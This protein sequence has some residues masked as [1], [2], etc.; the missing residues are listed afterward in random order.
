VLQRIGNQGLRFQLFPGTWHDAMSSI[1]VEFGTSHSHELR[2]RR[3]SHDRREEAQ[4]VSATTSSISSSSSPFPSIDVPSSSQNK[5]VDQPFQLDLSS[6]KL[7][8]SIPV[9]LLPQI[10][11]GCKNCTTRGSLEVLTGSFDIDLGNAV[12]PGNI[13]QNGT[14]MISMPDGFN[15]HIELGLNVSIDIGFEIPIIDVPIQGF[16]V[17]TLCSMITL[18]NQNRSQR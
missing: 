6:E 4:T 12:T 11:F 16:T 3:H 10:S 18:A 9:P 2:V 8:Q 7:D 13:I 14:V 5:S 17:G 1:K 15:A